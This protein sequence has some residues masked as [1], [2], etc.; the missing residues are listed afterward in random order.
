MGQNAIFRASPVFCPS[1]RDILAKIHTSDLCMVLNGRIDHSLFKYVKF[2]KIHEESRM[3]ECETKTNITLFLVRPRFG[4]CPNCCD[5]TSVES[6]FLEL[7][8]PNVYAN[9]PGGRILTNQGRA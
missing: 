5:V 6:P 1:E 4:G 2:A 9:E 7:F 3:L 8:S